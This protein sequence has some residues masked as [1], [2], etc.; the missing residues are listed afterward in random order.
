MANCRLPVREGRYDRR[1]QAGL[2][3]VTVSFV[4]VPVPQECVKEFQEFVLGLSVRAQLT[5]WPEGL[6]EKFV[7]GLSPTEAALVTKVAQYTA[8]TGFCARADLAADM[9]RSIDE[10]AE[11]VQDM[12]NRAWADGLPALV[13]AS[14]D[15]RGGAE[16][17]AYS[18]APSVISRIHDTLGPT[19]VEPKR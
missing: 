4:M 13:M 6:V 1:F 15:P 17:I 3:E 5:T 10:V 19:P 14:P 8:T 9:D 18:V 11:M 16:A 7:S 2:A 12:A